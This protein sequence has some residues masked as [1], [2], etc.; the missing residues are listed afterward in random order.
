MAF[1]ENEHGGFHE[2]LP[3]EVDLEDEQSNSLLAQEDN[4]SGN[5]PVE[6]GH[7]GFYELLPRGVDLEDEQSNSLLVQEDNSSGNSPVENEQFVELETCRWDFLGCCGFDISRPMVNNARLC[8]KVAF[9]IR[10]LP[11]IDQPDALFALLSDRTTLFSDVYS[12]YQ[13]NHALAKSRSKEIPA[14]LEKKTVLCAQDAW[15]RFISTFSNSKETRERFGQK[16]DMFLNAAVCIDKIRRMKRNSIRDY[17]FEIYRTLDQ[18]AEG[19]ESSALFSLITKWNNDEKVKSAGISIQLD[20]EDV[21][22]FCVLYFADHFCSQYLQD[23]LLKKEAGHFHLEYTQ[24]DYEAF[25]LFKERKSMLVPLFEEA[26]KWS[27]QHAF[28]FSSV[29][30]RVE[31]PL[32]SETVAKVCNALEKYLKCSRTSVTSINEEQVRK[33]LRQACGNE[34]YAAFRFLVLCVVGNGMLF[35]DRKSKELDSQQIFDFSQYVYRQ[36]PSKSTQR[37]C[38]LRLLFDVCEALQMSSE[39]VMEN[40]LSFL[41]YHGCDVRS[42]KEAEIWKAGLARYNLSDSC[43]SIALRCYENLSDCLPIFPQELYCYH[44][45]SQLHMGGFTAFAKDFST[46]ISGKSKYIT[47]IPKTLQEQYLNQWSSANPDRKMI[48][49]SCQEASATLVESEAMKDWITRWDAASRDGLHKVPYPIDLQ[50]LRALSLEYAIRSTCAK[51][52][53][54]VL[55]DKLA[56]LLQ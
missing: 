21:V 19:T 12:C 44:N 36:K 42:D 1:T 24:K 34:P 41:K 55:Q 43:A 56:T 15:N 46:L 25:Q 32:K 35:S 3:R 9:I 18:A 48:S 23:D 31:H 38:R 4:S 7:S 29:E 14:D 27:K 6:N 13:H 33:V 28:P 22:R 49:L 30:G 39:T 50:E 11:S 47:D 2:L 20:E 52:A 51:Q 37:T 10:E 16:R 45:C 40:L 8:C 5:L 26:Q 53:K 54:T 17:R